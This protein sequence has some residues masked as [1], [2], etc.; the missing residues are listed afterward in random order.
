MSNREV[1]VAIFAGIVVGFFLGIAT[2][3]LLTRH[4]VSRERVM[5][6]GCGH[7]DQKTGDFVVGVK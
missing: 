7:Y 6:A 2:H 3:G 1:R 4:Y 5:N